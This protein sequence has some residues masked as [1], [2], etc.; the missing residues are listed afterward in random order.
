[1]KHNKTKKRGVNNLSSTTTKKSI[2]NKIPKEEKNKIKQKK[3]KNR[4]T[5][6]CVENLSLF[7]ANAAGLKLKIP[8]LKSELVHI[9]AGIFTIQ[10][11]HFRKKGYLAIEGWEIFE[12]IRNKEYGGTMIGVKKVLK[13]IIIEEYIDTFE[14]LV[15]ETNIAG[16]SVRIISGYGPQ[17]TWKIQDKQPFF[18]A[19]EEEITKAGLAGKSIMISLDANCKLG[20]KW[21]PKDTRII[22]QNGKIMA[23]ILSRHA[24]CVANGLHGKSSGTITRKR[25]TIEGEESSTIDSVKYKALLVQEVFPEMKRKLGLEGFSQSIWMQDGASCHRERSVLQ[26]LDDEFGANML[27]LGA[28]R[29]QEWSPSSP[30]LNVG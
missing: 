27:A 10:E 5:K 24:L 21:I 9:E 18:Q 23:G 19:L 15:V 12:A 26:L 2:K 30:D 8:S 25:T 1:M 20:Q 4:T 28:K 22:S 3:Q 29:G 6:N 7:T 13:P 16:K 14:L 11:T 17:E